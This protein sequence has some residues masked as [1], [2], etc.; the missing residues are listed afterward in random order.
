MKTFI[1]TA[2]N[3]IKDAFKVLSELEKELSRV[4][5]LD[6]E[7]NVFEQLGQIK[8]NLENAQQILELIEE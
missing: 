4:D 7:T 3:D 5:G 8:F 6:I 1:E 2:L